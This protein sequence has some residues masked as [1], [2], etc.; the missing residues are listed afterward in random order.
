VTEN[1]IEATI[2]ICDGFNMLLPS[3]AIGEV[4]S[5]VAAMLDKQPAYP[6]LLGEVNW[7]GLTVPL[8]SFEQLLIQRNPRL[9]GSHIAV[10]RSQVDTEKMP[11]FGVP[12]QAIP[13]SFSLTRETPIQEGADEGRLDFVAKYVRVRGVD[14]VIPDLPGIETHLASCFS[15]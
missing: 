1:A 7:R 9:R 14:A 12:V 4:I 15:R 11:F 3:A 5:G 6:W 13:A 2:C 8:I 10:M